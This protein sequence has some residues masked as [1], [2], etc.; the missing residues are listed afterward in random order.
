[1]TKQS[2]IY[3]LKIYIESDHK[4]KTSW[5][6]KRDVKERGKK[7]DDVIKQIKSRK[8]DYEKYIKP[9]RDQADIIISFLSNEESEDTQSLKLKVSN[10]YNIDE[11]I[12]NLSIF[13][14]EFELERK[15][16]YYEI[17]FKRYIKNDLFKDEAIKKRGDFYDYILLAIRHMYG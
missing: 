15:D 5:K 14:I 6:I 8:T 12:L 17:F 9:Q 10:K 4:L 16:H 11:L 3:D 2:N 1:V 7:Y 13:K